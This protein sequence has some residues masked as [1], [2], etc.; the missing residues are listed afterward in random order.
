VTRLVHEPAV[1]NHGELVAIL[2]D[3]ADGATSGDTLEA[4]VEF[5]VGDE[6]GS[7][8]VRARYRTGQTNGQGGVMIVGA[9]VESELPGP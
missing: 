5:T 4:F 9:F 2:R 3:V 6:A 1:C 8:L 7:W